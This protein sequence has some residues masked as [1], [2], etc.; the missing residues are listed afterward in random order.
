MMTLDQS[1][2]RILIVDDQEGIRE[3]MAGILEMEGYEIHSFEDG[4]KAIEK[5]KELSFDVAFLDVKMPG[6][7][8]VD[9]FRG[10]KKASP[11]TVVFMMTAYAEEELV[12]QALDE[13]A[14]ACIHKPFDMEKIIEIVESTRQ[15]TAVLI[16]D[17]QLNIHDQLRGRLIGKGYKVVSVTTKQEAVDLINRKPVDI[18]LLDVKGNEESSQIFES[19][20]KITG[21]ENPKVIMINSC[22]IGEEVCE[23]VTVGTSK[24]L[25]RPADISEVERT[26]SDLLK[27]KE[28]T[29]KPS[30]LIVDDDVTSGNQLLMA[31]TSSGYEVKV[32]TSGTKAIEEIKAADARVILINAKLPDEDSVEIYEKIKQI[33]PDSAV[34]MMTASSQEEAILNA[35][36]N[37]SFTFL[38]KPF[39]SE[40][41]V[42]V[43]RKICEANKNNANGT[44]DP[45]R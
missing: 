43:V 19:I 26:I 34:I 31:L 39:D 2:G 20:R 13:G 37:S 45:D 6:I 41:I 18:V 16:V 17:N 33:K 3:S 15:K 40:K 44:K 25:D 8:G 14:Y 9:T 36:K 21:E 27:E 28:I 12:K 35:V 24:F 4:Y 11:E 7:N 32:A 23:V 1:K 38:H 29:G 42:D 5:V 30:I 10:I 22:K